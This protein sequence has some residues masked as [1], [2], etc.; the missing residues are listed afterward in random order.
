MSSLPLV[1]HAD[2]AFL[3]KLGTS[4]VESGVGGKPGVGLGVETGAEVLRL[5]RESVGRYERNEGGVVK[6]VE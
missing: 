6:L 3:F 5:L 4:P 2:F 1:A